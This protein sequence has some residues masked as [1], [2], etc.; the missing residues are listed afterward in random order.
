MN[1]SVD[2]VRDVLTEL[3]KAALVS[4]DRLSLAFRNEA[5]VGLAAL[6]AAPPDPDGLRMDGAWTLAVRAAEAP[7]FQ[8]MEGR[9]NLTL[10]QQSPLTL[11]ALLAPDFDVDA[12][13]E[14]IRKAA[15]TG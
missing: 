4:E 8:P 11:D 15:S 13:V 1:R 10:P 6:R 9:I 12:A 5:V 7:E 14:R 3:V 2:R